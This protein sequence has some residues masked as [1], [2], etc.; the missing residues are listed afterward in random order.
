MRSSKPSGWRVWGKRPGQ[1]TLL[2]LI[3]KE[4]FL[5][6]YRIL[7]QD[8]LYILHIFSGRR[9]KHMKVTITG[10]NIDVSEYL[11]NVV[12]KK[13][14]KLSHYFKANTEMHVTLAIEKSRHIAEITVMVDGIVL[15]SEEATGDMYSSIDVALK[16]IE[17]QMRKHRTKLE[18][19]LHDNAFDE[20]TVYEHYEEDE[21]EPQIVRNKKFVARPMEIEDAIMQM[22]LVSHNFFVF[23]NVH[24]NEVNVLYKRADGNYGIIEPI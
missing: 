16:K 9:D 17:R 1:T 5:I 7:K 8:V 15:R 2:Y 18:K 6:K 19:R 11:N 10:K 3:K 24:S 14:R 4:D 13:A 21:D 23:R 12:N 22:E 20:E